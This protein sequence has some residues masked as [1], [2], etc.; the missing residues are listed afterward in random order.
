MDAPLFAE[1]GFSENRRAVY[2]A[3]LD[4]GETGAAAVAKR[5]ALK[6]TTVYELLEGLVSDGLAHEGRHGSRRTFIAEDPQALHGLVRRQEKALGR[7]LP[8]LLSRGAGAATKPRLRY[9]AGIDGVRRVNEMLL[10]NGVREYRYFGSVREMVE[11]LGESWLRQFV[12]RRVALGIRSR[13]IRV[14]SREVAGLPWMR[15]G[16]RYLREVRYLP[17]PVT[18]EL[19]SLYLLPDRILVSAGRKE[20]Y[21]MVVESRELAGIL[22]LLWESIWATLP[23]KS[24]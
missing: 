19:A 20:C 9:Y 8:L 16:G 21:G 1:L 12:R 4:M 2:L 14:R 15:E 17:R 5:A 10:E 7:L 13:A 18:G 23:G 22:G 6:R 3:L 11:L 24:A